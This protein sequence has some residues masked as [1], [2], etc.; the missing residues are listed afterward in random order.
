MKTAR[1]KLD[2]IT[3]YEETGS[4]R[5]AAELRGTPHK[6]LKRVV[7]KWRAREDLAAPRRK[8]KHNIDAF[9]D[10]VVDKVHATRGRFPRSGCCR[11]SGPRATRVGTELPPSGR[12]GEGGLAPAASGVPPLAPRAG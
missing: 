12:G 4:Y 2:I 1:E 5:A 3:A 11:S 6:A 8:V 9:R 10:L 7:E